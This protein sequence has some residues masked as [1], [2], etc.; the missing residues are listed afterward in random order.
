MNLLWREMEMIVYKRL[1]SQDINRSLFDG[2]IRTQ[3]VTKCWRRE[4]GVWVI[5]DAAFVDD[6]G[7]C[8][9][10]E[11]IRCLK[12]TAETGGLVV[13]A[14]FDQ[15]LAG[16]VSVEKTLFG[17]RSQYMDLSSIHV[18]QD[19]RGH[20]IG[21]MLFSMAVDFVRENGV[22]KL[23]ISGHSAVETQ[24]F[25]RS[26]GCKEAKEYDLEHVKREPCDCQLE[27]DVLW[28]DCKR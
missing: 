13:G 25:Y 26:L 6:W 7:D 5:R 28:R 15:R 12:N 1:K 24:A 4:N 2:F 3:K 8:E 14:F 27:Y 9:Y 21:K 10:R 19:M 23:Y 11:L 22:E 16:F 17:S 20:G 18:S